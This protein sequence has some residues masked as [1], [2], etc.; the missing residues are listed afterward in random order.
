MLKNDDSIRICGDYKQTINQVAIPDKY[1]LPK[2]DDLLASLAGGETFTKLD[3]AHAYQQL[4]LDEE[5]SKLATVNTHRGLFRYKRLPFGISAAP[6]I[7]QRTMESLLQGIPKVCVYIDDVLVTGHT[8]E[9]HLANLTEVLR[10][11]ASAGMRLKREKCFFMMSQ[12]HYLGHTVSSKSIQPT[13]D[14]VR[15]IRDAPAPTNIHQL[16]SFLGLIN[17]YAK[18]LPNLSTVLA[19]LY[20]LLQKHHPWTWG[21]SQQRAFQHAKDRLLLLIVIPRRA[22]TVAVL[23]I[24]NS[25]RYCSQLTHRPMDLAQYC[26]IRWQTDPRGRSLMP[27]GP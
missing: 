25:N 13:Q 10:R 5:S 22:I 21:P 8:E 24:Q 2:V 18:F 11:M 1:P 3:L 26:P 17:F 14:K 16:K 20:V 7:F 23:T 19:P 9:E 27:Q 12:V 6:A 15:A 4:V